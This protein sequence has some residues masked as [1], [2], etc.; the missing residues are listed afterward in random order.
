MD[1]H[2][3]LLGQCLFVV[4]GRFVANDKVF[5]AILVDAITWKEGET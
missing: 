2:I 3:L 5:V 4:Q 1:L